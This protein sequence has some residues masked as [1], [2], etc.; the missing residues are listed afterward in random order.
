MP[1]SSWQLR[2]S[3]P[4]DGMHR[5]WVT[6]LQGTVTFHVNGVHQERHVAAYL[7]GVEGVASN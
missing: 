4:S 7:V 1:V 3:Q 2:V 5:Q 6:A